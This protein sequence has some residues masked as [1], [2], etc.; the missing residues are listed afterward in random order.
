[1]S[2]IVQIFLETN[3]YSLP[4]VHHSQIKSMSPSKSISMKQR[5]FRVTREQIKDDYRS[6]GNLY[7]TLALKNMFLNNSCCS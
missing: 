5:L 2:T 1:M 7:V 6:M 3:I 4:I